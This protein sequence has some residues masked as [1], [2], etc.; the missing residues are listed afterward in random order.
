MEPPFGMLFH[1]PNEK[2]AQIESRVLVPCARGKLSNMAA[3]HGCR[4]VTRR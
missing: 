1:L 2:T 4:Q 3:Q